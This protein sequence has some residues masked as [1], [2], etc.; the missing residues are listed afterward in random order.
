MYCRTTEDPVIPPTEPV[1]PDPGPDVINGGGGGWDPIG[2]GN[3]IIIIPGNPE[4][5][6]VV[7]AAVGAGDVGEGA[8]AAA[9]AGA[10]L[11]ILAAASSI[12]WAFYK[13]K[14]GL[15]GAGGGGPGGLLNIS[16]PVS[17]ASYHPVN[18]QDTPLTTAK[19]GGGTTGAASSTGAAT[20][21]KYGSTSF[22]T[23]TKADM[24]NGAAAGGGSSAV[25]HMGTQTAGGGTTNF[26][27]YFS[28]SS[29]SASAAGGASSTAIAGHKPGTTTRAIQTDLVYQA[30]GGAMGGG[31]SASYNTTVRDT[32]VTNIFNNQQMAGG[33]YG[34]AD[35][36]YGGQGYVGQGYG[37][38]Y[39]ASTMSYDASRAGFVGA[40]QQE[41]HGYSATDGGYG[42]GQQGV[43]QMRTISP[44]PT[45]PNSLYQMR[46]M[47]LNYSAFNQQNIYGQQQQQQQ[48]Q[49]QQLGG[50]P[51]TAGVRPNLMAEEIRVD[52]VQM[53]NNGRYV[54]TGSIFGPP[55][56]WDMKVR[57]S[58]CLCVCV[59]VYVCIHIL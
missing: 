4:F 37:D 50:V 59:H 42:A 9:V 7:A 12:A 44:P 15:I 17:S 36:G 45:D 38:A 22:M 47:T 21:K 13:F 52:C 14:P 49:L 39:G 18:T 58:V 28:Y 2:E 30:P 25:A 5:Q 54:V 40:G 51:G 33:G 48:Q 56:V 19:G 1:K 26:S 8:R 3:N 24:A 31:S 46:S 16:A 10:M 32:T 27:E 53:T 6:P 29:S 55:Q 43:A 57:L 20:G 34:A 11:G 35:Q 41:F 23:T